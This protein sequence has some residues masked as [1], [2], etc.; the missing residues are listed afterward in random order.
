MTGVTPRTVLIALRVQPNSATICSFVRV[1][2]A[3]ELV[4]IAYFIEDEGHTL[5]DQVWTLIS[6]P[7]MYSS[8]S[9]PGRSITREPTTK[10]VARTSVSFN[11]L[12][13]V[14]ERYFS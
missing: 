12:S 11:F 6:W 1:V 8:M 10:K 5:W 3:Y 13:R 7:L 2:R 9:I 14:L 4:S